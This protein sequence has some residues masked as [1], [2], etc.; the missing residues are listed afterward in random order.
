MSAESDVSIRDIWTKDVLTKEI[1]E[2]GTFQRD[3]SID[4][5]LDERLKNTEKPAVTVHDL[6]VAYD[7]KPVLWGID[8][9]I[10]S[11]KLAA[12]I[13][14][15]GAGKTTL[16]K[17]MLGLMKPISG[18]VEFRQSSDI[19][20]VPQSSKL[21][22]D[23]P[24]TVLD[25]AVMGRYGN[26]G[27]LKRP[28]R[29]ERLMAIEA[30]EKL[31]LSEFSNRQIGCLSGGQQQR[32]LL[33]RALLQQADIYLMDEPFKGVDVQTEKVIVKHL[34]QL[35]SQGKTVI[36]VHHDLSTVREYF[37]WATLINMRVVDNGPVK[38][39]FN[40]QNLV[41][42]YGGKLQVAL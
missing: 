29:A 39:V 41:R 19:A 10:P 20:Y 12:V 15:N 28:G 35:A 40:Q 13:G 17:A 22:W 5:S 37:D 26:L 21:D 23:F 11:G 36:V 42:L 34:K 7:G 3:I 27:L 30:L 4:D 31:G 25:V 1:L 33:A 6:T 14:P 18:A 16:I 8:L 24:A 2:R 38:Q 32:V 9:S